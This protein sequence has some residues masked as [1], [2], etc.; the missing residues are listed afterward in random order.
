MKCLNELIDTHF[1]FKFPFLKN[2]KDL[3]INKYFNFFKEEIE[4][5]KEEF[6]SFNILKDYDD[7][8]V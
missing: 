8:K 2:K 1:I 7:P 3:I 5:P 4:I 6:Y